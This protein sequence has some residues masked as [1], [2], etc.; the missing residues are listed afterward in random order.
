MDMTP[1]HTFRL[2]KV[3]GKNF[4]KGVP[5]YD[6]IVVDGKM[7]CNSSSKPW[8]WTTTSP[9]QISWEEC[10]MIGRDNKRHVFM[11]KGTLVNNF[12]LDDIA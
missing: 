6:R 9:L 4:S 2:G 7:L 3:R 10:A 12:F 5:K 8:G 1:V 11:R